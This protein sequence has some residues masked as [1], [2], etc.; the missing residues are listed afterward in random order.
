MP[1]HIE[2]NLLA[3]S[4]DRF[5]IVVA[6]FNDLVTDR[7][8]DGAIDTLRRHG[9]GDEKMS[10]AHVPGSFEIPIVADRFAKTGKYAAVICL[11]AV[12][13]GETMHHEYINHQV[14]A[15]IM[16]ISHETGV[17]TIFGVL[18]CQTT[19]QALARAGGKSGNKGAESALAAIETIN[20]LRQ[21]G[22]K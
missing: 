21:I 15:G 16:Q 20:V 22:E 19:D 17:P 8:L 18:T 5:A 11:G 14:A 13:Q 7:L 6:R 1:Q 2:G 9:V 10:I 4:N 3:D 12:I